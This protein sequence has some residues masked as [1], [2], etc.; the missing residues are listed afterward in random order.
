MS[1][2]SGVV[3]RPQIRANRIS[4]WLWWD[5]AFTDDELNQICELSSKNL[6]EAKVFMPN[7]EKPGA[8][9]IPKALPDK[10]TSEISFNYVDDDNRW[11]FERINSIINHVNFSEFHFDLNGYEMYQYAE[12]KAENSGHYVWHSDLHMNDHLTPTMRKL[13]IS[14]VLNEPGVDFEGGDFQF[15]RSTPE[16]LETVEFKKGRIIL[17]PSWLTHRVTPVTKGVRKSVVIWVLG[18]KFR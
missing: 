13:S 16:N 1:N 7:K 10:R 5:D 4:P 18:P 17:F 14:L 6:E 12:Y 3:N 2:Y 9:D 15:M 11:I 8:P